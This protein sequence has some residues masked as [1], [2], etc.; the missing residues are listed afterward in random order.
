MGQKE[1]LLIVLGV[2]VIGVAIAFSIELFRQGAIDNK[3]DQIVNESSHIASNAINFFNKPK[4]IG[5][6]GRSFQ[7]YVI[8]ANMQQTDNGYYITEIFTDSLHIIGT[9]TEVI[10][11]SDSIKVRTRVYSKEIIPEVIN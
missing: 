5:G 11:G 3:R 7:D 4:V 6:G 9:G 8:P 10:T 1:L 2:I